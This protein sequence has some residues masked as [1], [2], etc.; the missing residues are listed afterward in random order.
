M[1]RKRPAPGTSPAD[2]PQLG[3]LTNYAPN[4]TPD[5]QLLNDHFLEWGQNPS[6]NNMINKPSTYPDAANYNAAT[7]AS[8]QELCASPAA[9][10]A[11]SGQLARR[12]TPNQLVSRNRGCERP[13]TTTDNNGGH[14]GET[15]WEESLEE[16]YRR[17]SIAKRDAQAKR[18]QIPPFVQKLRKYGLFLLFMICSQSMNV[19]VMLTSSIVL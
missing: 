5:P 16:L 15:G 17:A 1:S 9:T 10:A 3:A 7:F 19:V 14:S 4:P 6:T 2:Y 13:P 11:T 8:N 18:K 12:Q